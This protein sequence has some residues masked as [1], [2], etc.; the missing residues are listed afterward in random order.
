MINNVH[1]SQFIPPNAAHYATGTWTQVA[2]QVANTAVLHKA[3]AAETTI[4]TFPI[5]IPSNSVALQGCKLASV[6]TDYEIL[7][8]AATS[9]T[10]AVRKI[11]RGADTTGVSVAS[12][13]VTQDLTAAT[14]AATVAKHKLTVT[15]T[16]PVWIDNDEFFNLQLTCVCA[17]TTQLDVIGAT[18]NF[19][20]RA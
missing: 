2:G 20:F 15:I 16:T 9:I 19:T 12:P 7:V 8:A 6:E 18:A 1:F 4:V 10:A 5:L 13:A 11:T 14:T 17:A 3:A